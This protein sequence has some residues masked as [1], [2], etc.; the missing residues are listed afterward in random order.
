MVYIELALPTTKYYGIRS[1]KGIVNRRNTLIKESASKILYRSPY[2]RPSE[3]LGTTRSFTTTTRGSIKPIDTKPR[4]NTKV[5]KSG[6]VDISKF[7]PP[8]SSPKALG[9]IGGDSNSDSDSNSNS[10]SSAAGDNS[11]IASG[12][13]SVGVGI[14]IAGPAGI[15]RDTRA[16]IGVS[17]IFYFL[18][19]PPLFIYR[20]KPTLYYIDPKRTGVDYTANKYTF[21]KYITL[22]AA[23]SLITSLSKRAISPSKAPINPITIPPAKDKGKGKAIL[24]SASLAKAGSTITTPFKSIKKYIANNAPSGKDKGLKKD[25]GRIIT[26]KG[27]SIRAPK[28]LNSYYSSFIN[29]ESSARVPNYILSNFYFT[30]F[31]IRT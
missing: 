7:P 5:T 17:Y 31:L 26:I 24:V 30:L 23:S 27:N 28:R 3:S 2:K 9:G 16:A 25:R 10:N 1:R 22:F 13:S 18:S 29:I 15:G 12:D 20:L 19:R 21:Y 4:R 11:G 8:L 14:V 6:K